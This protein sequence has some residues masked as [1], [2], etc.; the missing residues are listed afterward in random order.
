V[1]QKKILITGSSGSE[2]SVSILEAIDRV[3]QM[4]G[5][6]LDW[7]Y[8]DE[9]RKGDHICYISDLRKFKNH[10]PNWRI[11][12]SLD[13]ILEEMIASERLRQTAVSA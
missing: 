7:C 12:R 3:E 6:K 5:R 4:A 1:K 2:N 8:I 13:S 9:A 11:T 10:Y